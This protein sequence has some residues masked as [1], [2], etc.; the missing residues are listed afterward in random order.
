MSLGGSLREFR[1]C[2]CQVIA[3]DDTHLKGIFGTTMFATTTQ[4]ENEQVY[5]FSFGYDDLKNNLTWQW[6]LDC[7]KG[8]LG[9][10]DDLVFIFD[11]HASIISKVFPYGTH[12]I[13]CWHFYKNTK[14]RYHRKDITAIIDKA[15]RL[16][17]ELKYNRHMEKLQ[18][19]HHN[20]FDYV[21]VTGPYKWS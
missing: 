9:H 12:I 2:M 10:I 16:Y 18:S 6:F 5:Q 14:K 3:V 15:T 13:C 17:T 11:R 4:D 20:A 8:A 7:L 21:N 1:R 19:L